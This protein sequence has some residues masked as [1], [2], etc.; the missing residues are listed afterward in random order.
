MHSHGRVHEPSHVDGVRHQPVTLANKL[1]PLVSLINGLHA[2]LTDLPDPL[3]TP[4]DNGLA[5]G[6]R[7]EVEREGDVA[8]KG[9]ERGDL[10]EGEWG[11]R[12]KELVVRQG[13]K[14]IVEED[15]EKE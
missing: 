12:G 6:E 8:P 3:C 10:V 7:V 15:S 11:G 9:G 4:S 14:V 1:P 13:V 5:R 2:S